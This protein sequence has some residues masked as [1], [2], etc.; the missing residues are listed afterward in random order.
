MPKL[1]VFDELQSAI[2]TA[3]QEADPKATSRAVATKFVED[4][5]IAK[6]RLK[7]RREQDLQYQLGFGHMPRRIELRSGKVITRHAATISGLRQLAVQLR[8]RK[9]PALEEVEK[10]IVVMA[11]YTGRGKGKKQ[12]ITWAEVIELEAKKKATK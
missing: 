5:V 12:R 8:A 1:T 3:A 2:R 10:A 11:K 9:H 4:Y 6:Y 7:T